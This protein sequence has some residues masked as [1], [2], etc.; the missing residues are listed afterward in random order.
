MD[1]LKLTHQA[2]TYLESLEAS[3]DSKFCLRLH[4]NGFQSTASMACLIRGHM[5][6]LIHIIA[7]SGSS[8]KAFFRLLQSL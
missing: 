6:F 4:T 1:K 8:L 2:T 5:L 7:S 3:L